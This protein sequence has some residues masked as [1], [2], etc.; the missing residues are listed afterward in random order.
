MLLS[1]SSHLLLVEP[2][3]AFFSLVG[4]WRVVGFAPF[5]MVAHDT[6]WQQET[7]TSLALMVLRTERYIL[8]FQI[9]TGLSIICSHFQLEGFS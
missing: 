9:C 3:V 5:L 4:Q 2:T 6:P 7:P 8:L 1:P